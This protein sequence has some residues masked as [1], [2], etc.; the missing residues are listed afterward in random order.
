MSW[1]SGPAQTSSQRVYRKL[2]HDIVTCTM[3][4]GRALTE[5]EL[6]RRYRTSRTPI[7]EACHHLEREGLI[8]ILPY[9]G[10]RVPPL[11]MAEYHH[12][13]EVQ[14]I[15]EPAAAA[16]AAQRISSEQLRH[17]EQWV[18]SAYRPED[19]QSYYDFLE[20]N[21]RLHVGIGEA[22]A[23]ESLQKIISEVHT[24]L[25]RFFYLVISMDAYGAELRAEHRKIVQAI[26]GRNPDRARRSMTEHILHTMQRSLNLLVHSA[27]APLRFPT[28]PVAPVRGPTGP[29]RVPSSE[30]R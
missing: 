25:M 7:R 14:L 3:A 19:A 18:A 11:T 13:N 28:A 2:R 15:V 1:S 17:L 23:N 24:R 10:Y 4:P 5:Q 22:S 6:C 16:L 9:R 26:A 12:L 21:Y 29:R 20:A 30:S 8:E 27:A